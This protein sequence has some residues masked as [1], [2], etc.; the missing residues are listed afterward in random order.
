[1]AAV[2]PLGR[3]PYAPDLGLIREVVGNDAALPTKREAGINCADFDE[4]MVIV[5]PKGGTTA[6][7]VE[8]HFWSDAKD[9][10]PNG[11]FVSEVTAQTIVI[12]GGA[13]KMRIVRVGHSKSVWFHVTGL[14]GGATTVRIEVAGIPVYG[15]KGS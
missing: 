4:L 8:A 13:A 1:M 15:H 12:S 14:A 11:G 3:V 5:T 10:S 9:G 7:N 2:T 6:A